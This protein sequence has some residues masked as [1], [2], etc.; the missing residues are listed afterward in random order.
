[1]V[2]VARTTGTYRSVELPVVEPHGRSTILV[3]AEG[4]GKAGACM[5]DSGGPVA[6][7]EAVFAIAT[8]VGDTKRGACGRISQ[9]VLLGPQRAWIDKTLAS[10]GRAA[11]WR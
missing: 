10:W 8:W 6:Q 7:G 3:W 5:G 2:G 1:V 4:G 9:G 11:R